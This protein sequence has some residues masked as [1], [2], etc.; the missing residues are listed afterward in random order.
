Q[1]YGNLTITLNGARTVTLSNAGTIGIAGTFS[2]VAGATAYTIAGSTINFNGN[3]AQSIPAFNYYNLTSSS[4]GARTLAAVGTIGIAGVFTLGTNTYTIAGS[5]INFNGTIDQTI[6]AFNYNNLT[7]SST[8]GRTLAAAGTTGI[9]GTFTP[10]A[11]TYT[12]T[13][14][15]IDFNGAGAQTIPLFTYNHL[16]ASTGGTKTLGGAITA[17]GN[18]TISSPA[19]LDVSASNY[20]L[21][22]GGNF[23]NNNTL[24]A[25]NGTVTMNGAIAQTING[26]ATT[27]YNLTVTN[28]AGVTCNIP[29]RINSTV[30]ATSGTLS[31]GAN[32]V[33]LPSV[34]G[35][36]ARIGDCTGG[37]ITG[38]QWFMERYI[39][40]ETKGWQDIASPINGANISSWDSTLYMSISPTCPDGMAAGYNSVVYFDA[41]T[42]AWK[43]VTTCNQ[44]L[45]VGQGFEMW[46]ASTT[47]T[48]VPTGTTRTIGAPTVGTK[49][50]TIGSVA[51]S[52]T[53]LIG[54]PYQSPLLWSALHADNVNTQN[55]FGVYD[56]T[57]AGYSYWD[58][59][60]G[61]CAGTG[62]L[63]GTGGV[64][65]AYQGFWVDNLTASSTFAFKENHK[66]ASSLELV[67][68]QNEIE[69]NLL[70]IK[71]YSG[72]MLNS[73]E[74][75]VRFANGASADDDGFGD[76]KFKPAREKESPSITPLSADNH[77]LTIA[78][79]P[80]E[81][82]SQDISIIASV[83]LP[84]DYM[85]DLKNVNLISAY[86]CLTLED[87][88]T[89]NLIPLTGNYTYR[90]T[91]HS[92][93]DNE[94][95][96]IL[97]CKKSKSDCN[98]N[99]VQYNPEIR[100]YINEHGVNL[101]FYFDKETKTSVSV[102]NILGQNVFVQNITVSQSN[103][104]LPLQKT[105][106]IYII[107][108]STDEGTV[109]KKILY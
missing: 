16:T 21:N 101:S 55:Y 26:N 69:S 45:G 85:I 86:S 18:V 107:K 102:N 9:A 34:A 32:S 82:E 52:S 72:S 84:G 104:S 2:P 6:P 99:V 98:S 94:R 38:S 83:G 77:K 22:I 19:T 23:T 27:F 10:G 25:R 40:P 1:N 31:T 4:I 15:T 105:N 50:V 75:I 54:N 106:S 39:A 5:T 90:F 36:T 35:S 78:T 80:S 61:P 12:I 24:T 65:P 71:I 68:T 37:N 11:N 59:S 41:P 43:N 13:G 73:N 62:K 60:G 20:A 48:F 66:T 81:P 74:A 7:S 87:A 29:M 42:Q 89:G 3:I 14:S 53:A 76:I 100:T 97:H 28:A 70:R 8:G 108:I 57:V 56:E 91:S 103:L 95:K 17:N 33:V 88:S 92:T 46:L 63:A 47:T 79:Y 44:A 93:V 64:I 67:K 58:C 96:F 109:I 51:G 30:A 49:N